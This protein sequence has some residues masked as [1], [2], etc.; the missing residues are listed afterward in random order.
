MVDTYEAQQNRVLTQRLAD[1][2]IEHA[3]LTVNLHALTRELAD[4][5]KHRD[6][7][8]L[9]VA[10]MELLLEQF[11]RTIGNVKAAHVE[12]VRRA[13]QIDNVGLKSAVEGLSA[14]IRG[15]FIDD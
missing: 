2:Q 11:Q 12:L 5:A 9:E 13:A 10:E 6:E 1:T 14:A 7:L 8:T 15:H 4:V 3:S